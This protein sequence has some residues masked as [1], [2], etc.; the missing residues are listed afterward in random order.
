MIFNE[1]TNTL[2]YKNI[3][4][5]LYSRK[6]DVSVVCDRWVERHIS[7]RGLVLLISS[8]RS[9]GVPMLAP[10]ASSSEMPLI[11]CMSYTRLRFSASV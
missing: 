11:G 2:L 6:G 10:L 7:E 1:R 3:S 9:Q 5:T 4:L 8:S